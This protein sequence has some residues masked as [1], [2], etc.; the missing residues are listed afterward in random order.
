MNHFSVQKLLSFRVIT[1]L[2]LITSGVVC[3][4]LAT[5]LFYLK[6]WLHL[7]AR[8]DTWLEQNRCLIEAWCN[9]KVLIA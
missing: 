5:W 3:T 2:L 4:F 9:S 1:E 7:D 6:P 8:F